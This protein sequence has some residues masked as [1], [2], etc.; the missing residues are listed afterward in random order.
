MKRSSIFILSVLSTLSLQAQKA[1]LNTDFNRGIPSD[2]ITLDIDEV[3]A[4]SGFKIGVDSNWFTEGIYGAEGKA[5]VSTSTNLFDMEVSNWLITP[6]LTIRSADAIVA[7]DAK[8]VHY[9]LRDGYKVMISTTDTDPESFVELFSVKE[10]SYTWQHHL[11]SLAGYVGKKVYIAILHDSKDKFLLAVDNL[12]VGEPKDLAFDATNNTRHFC[13]TASGKTRVEGKIRNIGKPAA[14]KEIIC[15]S[16]MNVL[17]QKLDETV[18]ATNTELDFA[19]DVPVTLDTTIPYQ[20]DVK[21][22]AGETYRVL[23]DSTI[24]SYYPRT[25]LVEKGTGVWCTACPAVMGYLNEL[26]EEYKDEVVIVES[27]AGYNDQLK[28]SYAPYDQGMAASNY[29]T[30][31]FNRYQKYKSYDK[32]EAQNTL[33]KVITESTPALV[34]AEAYL[35]DGKIAVEAKMSFGKDMDNSKDKYRIGF[36]ILQKHLQL[37]FSIQ[38]NAASGPQYQEY[39]LMTSPFDKDFMFFHNTVKGTPSAFTGIANSLPKEIT[40]GSTYTHKALLDLPE[41]VTSTEGLTVVAFILDHFNTRVLNTVEMP[42]A[43]EHTGIRE[44]P[45][46]TL[47]A[48]IQLN[49]TS[50]LIRLPYKQSYQVRVTDASGRCLH[51]A[52]G[53]GDHLE[54]STAAWPKGTCLVSLQQGGKSL[55]KKILVD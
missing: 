53:Q 6:Q 20:I 14:L 33:K 16:G 49:G 31:Y 1:Y 37:P 35:Q 25:L 45:G 4:R 36:A 43:L 44:L 48:G 23:E 2:F 3:P 41:G 19:F 10:E 50:C 7:W 17:T 42:I 29:P 51:A 55:T 12:F 28:L 30:I 18:I 46:Q 26:K 22:V 47:E 39:G 13:G 11:I 27:H 38:K 8:S 24:C 52:Q 32:K 34:Q 9:D 54:L 15:T 40:A 5:A 21:T